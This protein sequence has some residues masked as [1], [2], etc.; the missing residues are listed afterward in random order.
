[1]KIL[2]GAAALLAGVILGAR[3]YLKIH[4]PE[5]C[6]AHVR[7]LYRG[8]TLGIVSSLLVLVLFTVLAFHPPLSPAMFW[9]IELCAVAGNVLNLV[10]LV[11]CLPEFCPET[12]F[13]A[14][15][16]GMNQIL[17]ILYA[18]LAMVDF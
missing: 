2:I 6:E 7:R 8:S 3:M 17:W 4:P 13:V 11:L 5:M 14:C 9:P 12:L 16:I 18:I 15:F 1:M 10:S